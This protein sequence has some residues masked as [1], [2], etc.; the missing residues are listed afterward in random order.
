[1]SATVSATHQP[2]VTVPRVTTTR[3][4]RV[5]LLVDLRCA[6]LANALG[7]RWRL[8]DIKRVGVLCVAAAAVLAAALGFAIA[9]L[10]AW[11]SVEVPASALLVPL[12]FAI[13]ILGLLGVVVAETVGKYRDCVCEHPNRSY[14]R[15]LDVPATL[16]HAVYV[17]PRVLGSVAVSV[18]VSGGIIA[19][20]ASVEGAGG[21]L[22]IAVSQLLL[23]PAVLGTGALWYSIH[24][25]G[26][27]P[28]DRARRGLAPAL[29][30]AVGAVAGTAVGLFINPTVSPATGTASDQVPGHEAGPWLVGAFSL[31]LA[32]L[33]LGCAAAYSRLRDRSFRVGAN[34]QSPMRVFVTGPALW[35]WPRILWAQ[36]RHSWRRRV[37]DRIGWWL[38]AALGAAVAARLFGL[39]A[40]PELFP[41]TDAVL[42]T[43]LT[44]LGFGCA[45]LGLSLAETTLGDLGRHAM[46][47]QLRTAI[48][49]GA[50]VRLATAAH[51]LAILGPA[52]ARGILAAAA[53]S[54]LLGHPWWPGLVLVTGGCAAAVVADGLIPAPRTT[55]GGTGEGIMTAL[56]GALLAGLPALWSLLLPSAAPILMPLTVTALILGALWWTHRHLVIMS[57]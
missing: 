50:S 29:F 32:L 49:L 21:W 57:S 15:A 55:D 51:L 11:V 22:W 26:Q 31:L 38:T 40:V 1:M 18:L 20:L 8:T 41:V 3:A 47:R 13:S 5:G 45:L 9:R 46:G 43:L 42:R 33:A 24:R 30:L 2:R 44:G 35:S 17:V 56:V 10:F 34:R 23:L 14:F 25:A 27:A 6:E 48:E 54:V 37:E 19:G 53:V 4:M 52:V 16:V 12:A 7:L 39:P 28:S 36:R